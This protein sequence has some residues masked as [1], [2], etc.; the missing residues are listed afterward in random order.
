MD[1]QPKPTPENLQYFHYYLFHTVKTL[2]LCLHKA[3]SKI[4]A[5]KLSKWCYFIPD[6]SQ[7]KQTPKI[8]TNFTNKTA[9]A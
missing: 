7:N 9:V 5:K 4:K 6:F 2:V 3:F 1:R 8:W